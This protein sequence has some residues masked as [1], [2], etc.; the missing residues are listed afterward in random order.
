MRKKYLPHTVNLKSEYKNIEK[1]FFAEGG[2]YFFMTKVDRYYVLSDFG[3]LIDLFEDDED[4]LSI[5]KAEYEF[6]NKEECYR[7]IEKLIMDTRN[8]QKNIRIPEALL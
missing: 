6:D 7:F 2:E 4:V 8:E 5:L 3:T 1:L